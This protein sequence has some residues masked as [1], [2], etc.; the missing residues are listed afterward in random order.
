MPIGKRPEP[1]TLAELILRM[2]CGLVAW[3]LVFCHGLLLAVVPQADCSPELWRT[4]LLFAAFGLIAALLLPVALPWRASLRWLALPCAPLW[5]YGAYVSAGL[6]EPA[7]I[8]GV[9][10]CDA[11]TNAPNPAAA[12]I[13]QRAW[14]PVQIATLVLCVVQGLRYW[15]RETGRP[16]AH[17]A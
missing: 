10:L 9:A 7:T 15:R 17:V 8:E 5:V 11:L 16:R 2:S 4:T 12:A 3:L 13:W 6:L 1:N 14:A